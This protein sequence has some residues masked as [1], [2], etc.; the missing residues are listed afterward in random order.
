MLL[1]LNWGMQILG[2]VAVI[3]AFSSLFAGAGFNPRPPV[4]G[5][6]P[7]PLRLT[8]NIPASRLDVFEFGQ[9]TRSYPVSPGA[10]GFETPAG[11]Y[12]VYR[13]VWNPWWHPPDSK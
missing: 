12:R 8:I 9:L 2:K 3:T 5:D 11:E 7:V 10:R 4:S 1:A 6:A 13:V